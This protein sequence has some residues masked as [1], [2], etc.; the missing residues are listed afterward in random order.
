MV[1]TSYVL[2]RF[3]RYCQISLPVNSINLYSHRQCIGMPVS[4]RPGQQLLLSFLIFAYLRVEN[5][6]LLSLILCFSY[7]VSAWVCLCTAESQWHF[8]FTKWSVHVLC[9]FSAR[10]RV[11]HW[12]L[13]AR[14]EPFAVCAGHCPL[15]LN[16]C[17]EVLFYSNCL[18]QLG[19]KEFSSHLSDWLNWLPCWDINT[20]SE[21]YLTKDWVLKQ[22]LVL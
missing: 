5:T 1:G 4:S 6:P 20:F 7:F 13:G 19:R 3:G 8:L 11:F 15:L 16:P 14:C 9:V 17:L 2:L 22:V 21:E 18:W 10:W 12:S